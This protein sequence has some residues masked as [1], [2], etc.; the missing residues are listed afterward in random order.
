MKIIEGNGIH[1]EKCINV[2]SMIISYLFSNNKN[3][4]GNRN[5]ML[6][7]GFVI[8]HHLL[9]HAQLRLRG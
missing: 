4:Q 2:F 9:N 7:K 5:G 8:T 6:D 1:L 3:Y